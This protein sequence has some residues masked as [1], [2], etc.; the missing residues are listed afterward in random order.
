LTALVEHGDS[1]AL[2]FLLLGFF[3]LFKL[4]C[5]IHI[6]IVFMNYGHLLFFLLLQKVILKV[7]AHFGQLNCLVSIAKLLLFLGAAAVFLFLDLLLQP[8]TLLLLLE[9]LA[10][11]IA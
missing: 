6:S 2:E 7:A 8:L 5:I 4:L 1:L 9:L 11:I 10:G 3:L